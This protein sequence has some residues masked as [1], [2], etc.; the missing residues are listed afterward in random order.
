MLDIQSGNEFPDRNR[1]LSADESK[2]AT[3]SDGS[4]QKAVLADENAQ[5]SEGPSSEKSFQPAAALETIAESIRKFFEI[6]KGGSSQDGTR[7]VFDNISVEGSGTGVSE[8]NAPS[9][10]PTAT[11]C[12]ADSRIIVPS[13]TNDLVCCQVGF[14]DPQPPSTPIART[15]LSTDPPRIRRNH[16]L[17]RNALGCWKAGE[18]VYNF[19]KDTLLYV[20]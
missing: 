13:S 17:G 20:G 7:V 15:I 19:S 9:P 11:Q 6:R 12:N 4:V 5:L 10:T 1:Q 8:D 2:T 18:R 16:R 3:P 14:R